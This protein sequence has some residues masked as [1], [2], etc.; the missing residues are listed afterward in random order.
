MTTQLTEYT[1]YRMETKQKLEIIKKFLQN[2]KNDDEITDF[3]D[4]IVQNFKNDDEDSDDEVFVDHFHSCYTWQPFDW[5]DEDILTIKILMDVRGYALGEAMFFYDG[6][7]L[8]TE[9]DEEYDQISCKQD[10]L[11]GYEGKMYKLIL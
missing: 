11:I 5:D 1:Y 8:Y 10:D 4:G 2:F 6:F 7:T 9:D 3:I